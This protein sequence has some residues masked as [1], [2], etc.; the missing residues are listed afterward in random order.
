MNA[1]Y[2]PSLLRSFA[3]WVDSHAWST[4]LHESLWVWP[5][6]ESTHVLTVTMF[7][8]VLVMVDLRLLGFA[9]KDTPVSAMTER[10]LPWSI[11][12]FVVMVITG[13]LLF[14]ANP[15]HLAH[16]VW[17]RLK[18]ILLVVAA[19]N[20]WMFHRRVSQNRERWDD[21][22]R[23]P[24]AVR[25][26]AATSVSVWCGVILAGRM[27]AYNW[28]ECGRDQSAFIAWAAGCAGI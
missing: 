24:L 28:F 25:L 26:T 3:E 5:L 9:F 13:L 23:L 12:G 17:F 6:V 1:R 8:G 22:T 27:I 14:Y 4:A 11:A 15:V 20:A 21:D 16:N 19:V 18:V 2:E 10:V 7:V